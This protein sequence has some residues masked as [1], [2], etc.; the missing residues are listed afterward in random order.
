MGKSVWHL[1]LKWIRFTEIRLPLAVPI[2]R[3]ERLSSAGR[4][5][6][7]DSSMGVTP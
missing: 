4:N 7:A 5:K 6:A 3:H 1:M 2:T